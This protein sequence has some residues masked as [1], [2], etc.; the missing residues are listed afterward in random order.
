MSE[1][2]S[3]ALSMVLGVVAVVIIV[4]LIIS[5]VYMSSQWNSTK[6]Q[7][8]VIESQLVD[9]EQ[10]L[11][12]DKAENIAETDSEKKTGVSLVEAVYISSYA[13]DDNKNM[14]VSNLEKVIIRDGFEEINPD[15]S[16]TITYTLQNEDSADLVLTVNSNNILVD[17]SI[18]VYSDNTK[19]E[20]VGLYKL[21]DDT[22]EI[23]VDYAKQADS[24]TNMYSSALRSVETAETAVEQ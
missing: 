21:S 17:A 22:L 10:T 24:S 20:V 23:V 19:S 16:K 7:L 9:A 11:Q 5:L 6:S 14:N 2:N 3:K 13:N 4:S 8:N 1:K 15:G 12:T 18:Q